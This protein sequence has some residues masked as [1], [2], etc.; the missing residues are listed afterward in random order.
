LGILALAFVPKAET[1]PLAAMI[2]CLTLL[3]TWRMLL[4]AP[5]R[6]RVVR[7]M[8]RGEPRPA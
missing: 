2:C 8:R 3:W 7:L 5:T 6:S 4:D 1:V